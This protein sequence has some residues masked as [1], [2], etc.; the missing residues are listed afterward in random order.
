[1][2]KNGIVAAAALTGSMALATGA[3]GLYQQHPAEPIFEQRCVTCHG[4]DG[5]ERAPKRPE[6]ARMAP[7]AIVDSLTRGSMAPMAAG[8][9]P[10][11][12]N[13][14]AEFLSGRPVAPAADAAPQA[15]PKQQPLPKYDAG[16]S[17]APS[18]AGNMCATHPPIRAAATDWRG[19]G[20]GVAGKRFQPNTTLNARNVDRLKVKWSFA[21]PGGR[22]G[23]PTVVGD[24]LFVMTYGGQTY[25]LD[26]NT[27]CVHWRR[28]MEPGRTS[29]VVENIPGLGPSGW[30]VFLG[31]RKGDVQAL[32]AMTGRELWKTNV[33]THPRLLLTGSP[34]FYRDTLYVPTSSAEET[35]ASAR[36]YGCCTFSGSVVALDA[37]TG[38]IK[39]K[40]PMLEPAKP[41]RK[42]AAGTQLYGPAGAAIWSQPTVD[43]RRNSL[44]VATG[45]S[46]T[47]VDAPR[48]DAI[49]A[50]DLTTGRIKWHNQVTPNDNFLIGCGGPPERRAINCPLGETGPD[51]DFGAAPVL[52]TL[53]NGRQILTAGQK[54]SE[55]YGLDPDTG[56]LIWEVKLGSGGALGGI[57]WGMAADNRR[58]FVTN[59]DSGRPAPG[60]PS[61]SAIDTAKGRIIW[62][63]KAPRV[64]CNLSRCSVAQSAPP[65]AIPGVVFAGGMDAWLRAY[66][67]E[68]GRSLWLFDAAARTYD[69]VN[70]VRDQRA[71]SFDATGPVVS[72]GM[73]YVIAGY[74]GATG[75][76]G[77]PTN[78]LLAFSVD[79]K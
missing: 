9:S 35:M 45:D 55:V 20:N 76:I 68:T 10:Q 15:A 61:V 52:H 54:S 4:P 19:F 51:V 40:T 41:S 28:D 31:D 3:F 75:A 6:L 60:N 74:Q 50:L 16:S 79:G 23:Q 65:T 78:A 29:P 2:L 62:Q 1:V 7:A 63:V 8:L 67:A 72:G 44:Y 43:P 32:D 26:K 47:E 27:G 66:N 25:A 69:T 64:P 73:M 57:E 77:Y 56:K 38:R 58:L 49:V 30:V 46:Y 14:L 11:Q 12:I 18:D 36:D 24:W 13:Q 53:P 5:D 39:W 42:N 17:A 59:S 34:V 70:G 71:G 37:K 21:L 48:S 33:E 22:Y